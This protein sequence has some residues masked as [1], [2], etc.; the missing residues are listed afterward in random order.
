MPPKKKAEPKVGD[1]LVIGLTI[2]KVWEDGRLGVDMPNGNRETFSIE[3]A[4]VRAI[5]PEGV[6]VPVVWDNPKR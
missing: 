1:K 4:D 5:D 2:V 3:R 6:T